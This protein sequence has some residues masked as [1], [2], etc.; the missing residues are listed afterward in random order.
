MERLLN[1]MVKGLKDCDTMGSKLNLE[2]NFKYTKWVAEY[3]YVL[4]KEV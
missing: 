3:L 4:G 1:R 2:R